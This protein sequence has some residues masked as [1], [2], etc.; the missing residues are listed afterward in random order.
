[1][2]VNQTHILPAIHLNQVLSADQVF[3]N[4]QFTLDDTFQNLAAFL[5]T[6]PEKSDLGMLQ[7]AKGKSH[8]IPVGI[9][10][11]PQ[12]LKVPW[13]KRPYR[14]LWNHRW[15]Y[16]KGPK[17]FFHLMEMV[18]KKEP[19]L[20]LSILGDNNRDKE[21]IFDSFKKKY[22]QKISTFGFIEARSDYWR[23][24]GQCRVLPVT[25]I[26]DF[27]GLSVLEAISAGVLP[28]LP[29]RMVY[30]ELIPDSLK[31]KLLYKDDPQVQLEG[32]LKE[33]ISENEEKSLLEHIQKFSAQEAHSLWKL[34]FSP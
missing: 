13:K 21:G 20:S 2:I 17:D 12:D 8:V 6:R 7:N 23:E 34:K 9:S 26:H 24:L 11:C 31:D 25:S 14:V 1:D 19:Q 27:L 16:D 10:L 28:L 22:P 30:P 4:S 3:F 5:K 33:G 18:L 15:E 32:L 29:H